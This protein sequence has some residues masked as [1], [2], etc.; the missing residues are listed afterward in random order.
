LISGIIL[1]AGTSSRLGRP[2]QLLPLAGKP[3]LQHA[4]DAAHQ[5]G[6]DEV[7]VVLGHEAGEVAATLSL[8]EGARTVFNPNY[9][10]GQSS[11]LRAGLQAVSTEARGA[12]VLLGDQP[13]ITPE[14]IRAVVRSFEEAGGPVVQAAYGGRP[15]HPVLF[16][17]RIWPEVETV[18]GDVGARDILSGH[19]EWVTTVDVGGEPPSDIDTWGDYRRVSGGKSTD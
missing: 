15:G 5:A 9:V 13:G 17:R 6:L 3:L 19:P 16:D 7:V 11:S 14:A 1:A 4:V 10:E 12:V 18:E 8:P 2:K